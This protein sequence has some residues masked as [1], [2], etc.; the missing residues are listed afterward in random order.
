METR[1]VS[2]SLAHSLSEMKRRGF[3]RRTILAFAG[4]FGAAAPFG[5]FGAARALTTPRSIPGASL[6]C[7]TA[8]SGE[9]L[10]GPPRQLK[11]AWNANAACTVAAAGRQRTRYLRQAQPRRRI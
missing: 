8:T 11:L 5:V 2:T 6:I 7:R 1:E 3:S 4:V 9:E 10:Q